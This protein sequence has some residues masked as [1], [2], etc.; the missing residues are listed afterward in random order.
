MGANTCLDRGGYRLR[1]SHVV[2]GMQDTSQKSNAAILQLGVQVHPRVLSA[3][4]TLEQSC[5]LHLLGQ[6]LD[7]Q[8]TT[9]LARANGSYADIEVRH[10]TLLQPAIHT[11]CSCTV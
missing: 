9:L 8:F 2:G 5:V 7:G 11:A 3:P 6:G 1:S 4:S 10:L